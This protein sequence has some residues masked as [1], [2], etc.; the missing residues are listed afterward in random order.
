MQAPADRQLPDSCAVR[1]RGERQGAVGAH[2][3]RVD[4]CRVAGE[5]HRIRPDPSSTSSTRS[6][7]SLVSAKLS[8]TT[9]RNR[10][11]SSPRG[12]EVRVLYTGTAPSQAVATTS[13]PSGGQRDRPRLLA[14][15]RHGQAGP[16]TEQRAARVDPAQRPPAPQHGRVPDVPGH[17]AG[18][19]EICRGI[20]QR[21]GHASIGFALRPRP[22][23]C[24]RAGGQHTL[25]H[26]ILGLGETA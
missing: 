22:P 21:L 5:H 17:R 12:S 19:A 14:A 1:C 13:A 2:R 24:R 18:D 15:D 11:G 10:P 7:T 3:C 20:S 8:G 25:A 6:S 16:P 26:H 4:G 23:G 9:A